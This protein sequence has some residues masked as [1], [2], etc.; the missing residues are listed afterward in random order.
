MSMSIK[1]NVEHAERLEL[2]GY[3][4]MMKGGINQLSDKQEWQILEVAMLA[5]DYERLRRFVK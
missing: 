1:E 3:T 5:N 4:I 2:G